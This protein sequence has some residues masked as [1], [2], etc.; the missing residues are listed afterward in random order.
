MVASIRYNTLVSS[1]IASAF[2]INRT[3]TVF[4]AMRQVNARRSMTH[5][6]KTHVW[7]P[8][9]RRRPVP[10]VTFDGHVAALR[11]SSYPFK[12][13]ACVVRAGG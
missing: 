4:K 6:S 10:R 7:S 5:V 11:R 8:F 2:H 1:F 9:G 3:S 12:C 13:G